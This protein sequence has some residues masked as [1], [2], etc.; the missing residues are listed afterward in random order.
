MSKHESMAMWKIYQSGEPQGIAV[1]STYR[2]LSESITDE[3]GVQIGTVTYAD[4]ETDLIPDGIFDS[5]LHKR[6]SFDFE[7]EIRAIYLAQRNDEG[8]A[9]VGP[10]GLPIT[11]DLDKLVET[12]YVSPNA[13]E[14]FAEV[15]R[16]VM[17][18]Y[19]KSW[20]VQYSSIDGDPVF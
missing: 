4:Y 12:V 6:K 13:R 16:D 7:R 3:R 20:P 15:V 18:R 17:A 11:V 9:P 8:W 2:R 14:W 10:P 5:F 19:G 1:R